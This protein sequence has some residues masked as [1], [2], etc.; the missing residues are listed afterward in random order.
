MIASL[1]ELGVEFRGISQTEM[2]TS[3]AYRAQILLAM[4]ERARIDAIL[5]RY[6]TKD[7]PPDDD[8]SYYPYRPYCGEC[9]KDDTTVVAYDDETTEM[10]Y[11]CSCGFSRDG[12]AFRVRP[13]Q[14]RLEGR[15]A[16]ALGL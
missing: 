12:F 3:G 14:A 13:G 10:T 4:R 7:V 5:G 16:D 8:A 1:D 11:T 9:G 6:R 15:L 2:Y